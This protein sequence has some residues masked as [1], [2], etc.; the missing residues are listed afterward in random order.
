MQSVPVQLSSVYL[1]Y[2][3]PDKQNN[4]DI[5]HLY[6]RMCTL[7]CVCGKHFGQ[8]SFCANI[9]N[10]WFWIGQLWDLLMTFRIGV[11]IHLIYLSASPLN[12]HKLCIVTVENVAGIDYLLVICELLA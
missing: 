9:A 5:F 3:W 2:R 10:V 12:G 7:A 11:N 6:I 1:P 8:M 4:S